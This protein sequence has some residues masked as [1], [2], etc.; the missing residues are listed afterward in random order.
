MNK[1][2]AL[3]GNFLKAGQ[4]MDKNGNHRVVQCVVA[5]VVM[6]KMPGGDMKP[7]MYFQGKPMGAVIN[8]TSWD[9]MTTVYPDDSDVWIG[10]PVEVFTEATKRLDGSPTRGVRVR[11]VAGPD[12]AAAY[13]PAPLVGDPGNSRLA[14]PGEEA[15]AVAKRAEAGMV[16]QPMETDPGDLDDSIL[17]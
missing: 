12:T 8:A 10:K 2:T 3:P 11:P 5:S 9:N 6:E 1:D 15:A 13:A 4:L 16:A 7:V 14:G 17:F